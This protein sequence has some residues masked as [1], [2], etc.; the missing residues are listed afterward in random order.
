MEVIL[1]H[2]MMKV[3]KPDR[4][5]LIGG[6]LLLLLLLMRRRRLLGLQ[7]LLLLLVRMRMRRGV[8]VDIG[9]VMLG[10]HHHL[11]LHHGHGSSWVLHSHPLLLI[12][13]RRLRRPLLLVLVLIQI[14]TVGGLSHGPFG[15]YT[16]L[17]SSSL[18]SPPSSS[19][20]TPE[21]E[22]QLQ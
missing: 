12:L 5:D 11:L 2:P 20:P 10:V 19:S 9:H 16:L 13:M 7:L 17:V 8:M 21:A 22:I 15:S 4:P 18:K 3:T 1:V 6:P 14:G